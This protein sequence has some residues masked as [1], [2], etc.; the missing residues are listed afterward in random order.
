M[1]HRVKGGTPVD[2][3]TK[4]QEE[5]PENKL[6]SKKKYLQWESRIVENC[7]RIV[8]KTGEPTIA[9]RRKIIVVADMIPKNS[10]L[11]MSTLVKNGQ[12]ENLPEKHRIPLYHI[13]NKQLDTVSLG[14]E[15]HPHQPGKQVFKHPATDFGGLTN[16]TQIVGEE[17]ITFENKNPFVVNANT[18]VS[19]CTKKIYKAWVACSHK[20]KFYEESRIL[21]G[22]K[23]Y[24]QSLVRFLEDNP[25]NITSAHVQLYSLPSEVRVIYTSKDIKKQTGSYYK[26]IYLGEEKKHGQKV[27]PN[28]SIFT[29]IAYSENMK[30][31]FITPNINML[32]LMNEYVP[33][34]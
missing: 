8:P 14:Y 21:K 13:G 27:K 11:P 34:L 24:I 31:P 22:L 9:R 12:L 29:T 2:D 26:R 16:L 6:I 25:S 20:T 18:S 10:K 4:Q 7:K 19:S 23:A 5:I 15:Q 17:E 3:A 28:K 1:K 32:N 30:K 33:I